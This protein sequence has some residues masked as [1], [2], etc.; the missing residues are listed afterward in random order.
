MKTLEQLL[1]DFENVPTTISW[2]LADLGEAKGK[3]D[4]FTKQSPQKLKTLREHAL[5]ESAVS[6]NRIEG[7]E[8][9]QARIGTVVFGKAF[10]RDRNEEEVRGYRKTLDWIHQKGVKL[11]VS[12]KTVLQFHKLTRGEIWDAGKYKEKD[13]DIIEKY[14]DGRERV[15]FKT[16]KASNTSRYMKALILKWNDCIKQREVHPLIVLAAFSLDFLCIHPFRDGNGRVSRLLLLLQCYHLG[17]EV[18]H[19][20]S[21]ERII[22]ENKNRYYETLEQSSRHWHEGKHDPWPYIGYVLYILKTAYREFEERMGDLK[23]P[24]GEKTALVV[25][26]IRQSSETFRIADIQRKCPSISVDM[27]RKVLKDLRAEGRTK[28]LG[29]GKTAQW[30]RVG[31]WRN[32]N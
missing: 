14:P 27:I 9:N 31:K 26:A 3:Q 16:V 5:I 22:E 10:L 20:I 25:R 13:G 32:L 12:E 28:C 23:N 15:R 4:L 18:G 6:S 24:R 17:Y 30:K 29:R 11:P 19:F 2:Y 7:V 21:L 1:S 8:V